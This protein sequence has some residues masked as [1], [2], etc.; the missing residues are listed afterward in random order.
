MKRKD[1]SSIVKLYE[2]YEN[3]KTKEK[4]FVIVGPDGTNKDFL[5][6]YAYGGKVGYI[7]TVEE[8]NSKLCNIDYAAFLKK[9]HTNKK[10]QEFN[11]PEW[12]LCKYKKHI[13]QNSIEDGLKAS[14]ESLIKHSNDK[15]TN[16]TVLVSEQ[17]LDYI[18][19]AAQNRWIKKGN[20]INESERRIQTSLVKKFRNSDFVEGAVVVTDMEYNIA[21]PETGM[22]RNEDKNKKKR[23][24]KKPDIIVFDGTSFGLVELKFNGESLD[25]LGTHYLDFCN[26]LAEVNDP[27]RKNDKYWYKKSEKTEEEIKEEIN[28]TRWN[29]LKECLFRAESLCSNGLIQKEWKKCFD[30]INEK[31]KIQLDSKMGEFPKQLLWFGFYFVGGDKGVIKEEINKQL[32][33]KIQ[34]SNI[35]P[36][37]EYCDKDDII[38]VFKLKYTFDDFIKV[39]KP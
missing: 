18:M 5:R 29:I 30:S 27:I 7:S 36:R 13:P 23:I 15:E 10:N 11:A 22:V 9:K 35:E 1:V 20:S 2:D 31:Y 16:D 34:E 19:A 37:F 8:K 14:F 26:W 4:P 39:L 21:M 38:D 12:V 3:P 24:Y 28:K 32:G 25:N 6:I 17:Y 33:T